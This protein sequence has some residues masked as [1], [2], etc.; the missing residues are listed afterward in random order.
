MD[1][2]ELDNAVLQ[3]IQEEEIKKFEERDKY[4]NDYEEEQS[5]RRQQISQRSGKWVD[6]NR[7]GEEASYKS[8]IETAR[9]LAKKPANTIDPYTFFEQAKKKEEIQE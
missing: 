8:K 5:Q 7:E 2:F 1:A 9:E 6:Q 4:Y 3:A